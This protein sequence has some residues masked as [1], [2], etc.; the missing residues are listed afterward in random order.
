MRFSYLSLRDHR[1]V[2][3][4]AFDAIPAYISPVARHLFLR[5]DKNN[6]TAY[7]VPDGQ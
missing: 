5:G 4:M 1:Y 3:T 6:E 7:S 2:K